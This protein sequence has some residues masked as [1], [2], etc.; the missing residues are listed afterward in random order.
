MK[1][2]MEHVDDRRPPSASRK[3]R[4]KGHREAEADQPLGA[5][6][7]AYLLPESLGDSVHVVG[8]RKRPVVLVADGLPVVSID[9][10]GLGVGQ[11]DL[12]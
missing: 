3:S 1:C 10:R 6:V 7:L 11:P 2:L 8:E 12:M 5:V 9:L 4:T